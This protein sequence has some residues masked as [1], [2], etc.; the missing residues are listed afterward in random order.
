MYVQPS[1][2]QLFFPSESSRSETAVNLGFLEWGK[3]LL[4]QK[5]MI[6]RNELQGNV[7]T[8]IS[9]LIT[10][11][12]IQGPDGKIKSVSRPNRQQ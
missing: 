7:K 8:K 12:H 2:D 1:I 10:G 11:N 6:W 5:S 3:T 9:K 4:K